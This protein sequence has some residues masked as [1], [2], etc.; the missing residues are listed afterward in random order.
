MGSSIHNTS[1]SS[2]KSVALSY[3]MDS[4]NEEI[5]QQVLRQAGEQTINAEWSA[6]VSPLNSSDTTSYIN[7]E[8]LKECSANPSDTLKDKEDFMVIESPSTVVNISKFNDTK[9]YSDCKTTAFQKKHKP[10]S[11]NV[12]CCFE[13]ILDDDSQM[14][15][16]QSSNSYI[17]IE[18]LKECSANPSDTLKDKEHFMVIE[19]PSTVI[20][21]SKFNDTKYYSQCKTTE[22]QKKNTNHFLKTLVVVLKI[23]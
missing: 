6:T 21:I 4:S 13:N 7:I 1:T 22:F 16:T 14:K 11:Q 19:S 20:N 9:Y 17:N 2:A 18:T 5:D 3:E 8:T 23:F 12:S 15:I 10:L